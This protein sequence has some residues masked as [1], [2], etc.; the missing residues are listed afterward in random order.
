MYIK[1]G[2]NYIVLDRC[3]L[4]CRTFSHSMQ[5]AESIGLAAADSARPV[6]PALWSMS[7]NHI[8]NGGGIHV[9][10]GANVEQRMVA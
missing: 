6:Q 1:V 4:F 8:A 9:T 2:R 3:L 10:T 5:S 7:A